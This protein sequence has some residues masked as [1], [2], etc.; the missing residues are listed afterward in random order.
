M[1]GKK[2]RS[3][4]GIED[5]DAYVIQTIAGHLG[6]YLP[7]NQVELAFELD[8][9]A[10]SIVVDDETR[11]YFEFGTAED[12]PAALVLFE[13]LLCEGIEATEALAWKV[14]F[15]SKY[16]L[17]VELQEVEPGTVNLVVS[18]GVLL[19]GDPDLDALHMAVLVKAIL[20]VALEAPSR[21]DY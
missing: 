10:P 7:G 5:L 9:D 14:A 13:C 18:G 19:A 6:G 8:S 20:D 15:T 4:N 2:Q 1:F 3:S 16:L 12:S 21:Y 17:S 11:V